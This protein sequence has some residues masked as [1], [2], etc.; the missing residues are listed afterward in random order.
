MD[1]DEMAGVQPGLDPR[2]IRGTFT[3]GWYSIADPKLYTLALADHL[4]A[5]GGS[6][7]I[8]E[9]AALQPTDT[10][11]ELRATDGRSFR[12]IRKPARSPRTAL[13]AKA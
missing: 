13:P 4:R 7:E 8:A 11:V 5:R 6:L 1:A 2:F 9:I 3:P 12:P 10:G